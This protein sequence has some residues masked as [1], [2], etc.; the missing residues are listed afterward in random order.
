MEYSALSCLEDLQS[1]TAARS[2][3]FSSGRKAPVCLCLPCAGI[4]SMKHEAWLCVCARVSV[5]YM[6]IWRPEAVET[7]VLYHCPPY[8]LRQ[9]L[10]LNPG[11]TVS[12]STEVEFQVLAATPGFLGTVGICTQLCLPNTQPACSVAPRTELKPPYMREFFPANP[13]QH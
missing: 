8:F 3:S 9:G 10:P 1:L 12:T 11:L 2:A 5:A 7:G 13:Q 6:S 4:T